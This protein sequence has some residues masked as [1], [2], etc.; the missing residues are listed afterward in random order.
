MSRNYL[1]NKSLIEAA[2]T[3]DIQFLDIGARDGIADDL[4]PLGPGINTVCFEPEPQEANRLQ[5]EPDKRWLSYTVVPRAVGGSDGEAKLYL[6][7]GLQAASLLPHNEAMIDE[8][9]FENL[10]GRGHEITVHCTTL[11]S[12]NLEGTISKISY[13]KIDIEGGELDLLK[14]AERV[15]ATTLAMRVEVSFLEQRI[16][17]PIIWDVVDWL[18][19]H[20]FD[21]VDVI[22]IHRWRRR[23]VPG[24]PYRS[25]FKMPFSKGR[26]SQ[27]D[28]IVCRQDGFADV[29]HMTEAVLIFA[30]MGY[31]DLAIGLLRKQPEIGAQWI[32]R[33]SSDLESALTDASSQMGGYA[34]WDSLR[35]SARSLVP[36]LKSAL[37][38]ISFSD[39]E[40]PY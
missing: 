24:A 32:S 38:G 10:H 6:P 15:L 21:V 12:L 22:D 40:R 16:G 27:C 13:M 3:Y 35:S 28:L 23:N 31:F 34:S 29:D 37:W 18:R 7:V 17:Q 20:Q 8:F 39:P 19:Q 9:G 11:D 33:H 1:F 25:R 2:K 4:L 30:A 5:S 26:I 36:A 14:G